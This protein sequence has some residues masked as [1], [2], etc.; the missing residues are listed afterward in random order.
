MTPTPRDFLREPDEIGAA[1]LVT[2]AYFVPARPG[3]EALQ[4]HFVSLRAVAEVMG[5]LAVD[6]V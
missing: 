5:F 3:E 1:D 6:P 4:I 2:V